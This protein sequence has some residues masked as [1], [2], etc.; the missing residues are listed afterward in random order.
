MP[1]TVKASPVAT[2]LVTTRS[3]TVPVIA[4]IVIACVFVCRNPTIEAYG[5]AAIQS[6]VAHLPSFVP[7]P[8][9]PCSVVVVEDVSNPSPWFGTI[10]AD[11]AIAAHFAQ[12]NTPYRIVD[13][14]EEGKDIADVQWALD[15]AKSPDVKFPALMIK[16]GNSITI[17]SCPQTTDLLLSTVKKVGGV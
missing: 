13:K 17:K 3:Y 16:R 4:I 7:V 1:T 5:E 8:S 9:G 15:K 2:T 10:K 11:P 6:I 14:D 12:S